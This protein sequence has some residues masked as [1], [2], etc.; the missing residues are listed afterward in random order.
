[1]KTFECFG[2]PGQFCNGY[3]LIECEVGE[4]LQFDNFYN[5]QNEPLR[6]QL[7]KVGREFDVQ[8]NSTIWGITEDTDVKEASKVFEAFVLSPHHTLEDA[9]V[10]DAFRQCQ[11]QLRRRGV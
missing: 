4:M 3:F 5:V 1:M 8:P 6:M 7:L 11:V 10:C 2:E 9:K